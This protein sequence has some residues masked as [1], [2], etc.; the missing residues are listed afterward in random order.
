M[1]D[2]DDMV[3]VWDNTFGRVDI[4]VVVVVVVGHVIVVH[5]VESV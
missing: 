4:V 3:V 5:T 2:D 1:F